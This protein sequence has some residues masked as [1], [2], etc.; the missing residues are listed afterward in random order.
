MTTALIVSLNVV[1]S[2]FVIFGILG[3][4]VWS[5]LTEGRD[6]P[7][8]ARFYVWPERPPRIET[9]EFKGVSAGER[10]FAAGYSD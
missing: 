2:G 8:R 5:I 10:I 6:H 9:R 3:L 7:I 4:L 1:L